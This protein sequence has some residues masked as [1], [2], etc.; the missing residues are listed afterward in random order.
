M[1]KERPWG[2]DVKGTQAAQGEFVKTAKRML[3]HMSIF[4]FEAPAPIRLA[5]M[6]DGS[7]PEDCGNKN[8]TST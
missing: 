1:K 4:L 2:L 3:T 6:E 8:E 7:Y 5:E